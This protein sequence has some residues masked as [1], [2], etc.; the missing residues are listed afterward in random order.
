MPH[1]LFLFFFGG[2]SPLHHS[3]APVVQVELTKPFLLLLFDIRFEGTHFFRGPKI[4]DN[5]TFKYLIGIFRG[6]KKGGI[7]KKPRG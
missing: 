5:N 4:K 7:D 6:F 3:V 1:I 2:R